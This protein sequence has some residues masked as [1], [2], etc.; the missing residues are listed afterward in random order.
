[1]STEEPTDRRVAV[2]TGASSGIGEATAR[3]LAAAGWT[4]VCAARRTERVEAL[5]A[6]I[7][8]HAVTVDVTDQ[9]SVDALDAAVERIGGTLDLVVNV[10][11]GALGA[12]PVEQAQLSQWQ[13]MYDVNV[14]GTL[15]VIKALLPRLRSAPAAQIVVVTSTAAEV[16][17]EGGGGY[18]AAKH[19][20]AAL[21][22]TLRLELAGEPIRVCEIAPGMVAT[23]EFSLVRFG[24]DAAKA[25]KTYEGVDRPLTADDVAR[26]ITWCATAPVHLNVDLMVIRPVAQAAQHKVIRRPVFG[27]DVP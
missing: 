4:V 17:Y 18:S 6:D 25:D 11:G 13:R 16:V 9:A 19:A 7:G 3:A 1:M 8:G 20:E 15:R 26:T 2:V 14:L 24:G 27:P 5:A 12:D 23:A 21:V 22:R 10:A